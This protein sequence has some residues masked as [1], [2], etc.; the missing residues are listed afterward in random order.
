MDKSMSIFGNYQE[1]WEKING[2]LWSFLYSSGWFLSNYNIIFKLY[3]YYYAS[4]II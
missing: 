4:L 3:I 2:I 1:S